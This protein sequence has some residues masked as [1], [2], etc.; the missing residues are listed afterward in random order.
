MRFNNTDTALVFP[1]SYETCQHNFKN[2]DD[3]WI[4][5]NY[6]RFD[7]N[8]GHSCVNLEIERTLWLQGIRADCRCG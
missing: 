8:H 4:D 3:C 1:K 6:C 7:V 2:K 5:F